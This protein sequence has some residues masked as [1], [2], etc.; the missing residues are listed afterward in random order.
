[1][2]LHDEVIEL[3]ETLWTPKD[4]IK[5]LIAGNVETKSLLSVSHDG[6]ITT[7]EEC[8]IWIENMTVYAKKT[9]CTAPLK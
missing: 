7:K 2:V 1:V 6:V 4:S 3:S 8:T 5:L 9:P